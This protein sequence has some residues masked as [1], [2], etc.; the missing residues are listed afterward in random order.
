MA[1]KRSAPS[2]PEEPAT[3][4][5]PA[6][7][8]RRSA[9]QL[10]PAVSQPTPAQRAPGP[11]TPAPPTTARP[12]PA[13]AAP[14]P[15]PEPPAPASASLASNDGDRLASSCEQCHQRKVKCDRAQPVC[16]G[17]ALLGLADGCAPHVRKARAVRRRRFPEHVLLAKIREHEALLRAHGI[18][19][20]PLHPEP[21]GGA[22][23]EVGGASG[24]E[25]EEEEEEE[26]ESKV[27]LGDVADDV[28]N[29]AP[30]G[31]VNGA[32]NGFT[33]GGGDHYG[34]GE[35][36]YSPGEDM[37]SAGASPVMSGALN[38]EYAPDSQRSQD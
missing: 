30:N 38:A 13:P 4:P 19:F 18:P 25:E 34:D 6:R 11:E 5:P 12:T 27:D 33:N 15:A 28:A 32:P 9:R 16:G 10:A 24:V 7:N 3:P 20:A 21:L 29:G 35:G 26:E 22:G 8:F 14:A 36:R 31:I 1:R 23:L 17:C 37:A 2:D